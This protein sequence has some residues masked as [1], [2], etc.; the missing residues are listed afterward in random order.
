MNEM[1]Q[2]EKAAYRDKMQAKLEQMQSRLNHLNAQLKEASAE[3]RIQLQEEAGFLQQKMSEAA[4]LL[5][6]LETS[7]LETYED[8]RKR[9]EAAY[10][11]MTTSPSSGGNSKR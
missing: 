8:I 5:R 6:Q 9:L 1:T 11:A 4:S 7:G 2:Q 3:T 10:E